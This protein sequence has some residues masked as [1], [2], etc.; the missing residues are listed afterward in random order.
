[1]KRYQEAVTA[2]QD[3]L[4]LYRQ[5]DGTPQEEADCLEN[6]YFTSCY[7]VKYLFSYKFFNNYKIFSNNLYT[8]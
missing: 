6:I 7:D 4:D 2:F 5:V 1:M 3:A 8:F